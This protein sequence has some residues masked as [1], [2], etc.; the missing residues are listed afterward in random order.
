ME[1]CR[2]LPVRSDMNCAEDKVAFRGTPE[3]LRA[4]LLLASHGC[5]TSDL[6]QEQPPV[7]AAQALVFLL[8]FMRGFDASSLSPSFS[9]CA[10]DR[11]WAL[12]LA[13]QSLFH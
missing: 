9:V 1:I 2:E 12:R 5:S 8:R 6:G 11:T 3:D 7:K 10:G 4:A 13:G